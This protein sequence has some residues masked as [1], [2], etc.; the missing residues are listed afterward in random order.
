MGMTAT[1]IYTLHFPRFFSPNIFDPPK[2]LS[3]TLDDLKNSN[4]LTSP[5]N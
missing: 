1:P 3:T 4:E 2:L 5:S